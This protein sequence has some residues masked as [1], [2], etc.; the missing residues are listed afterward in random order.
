MCRP[1][2]FA[3]VYILHILIFHGPHAIV[4]N[5]YSPEKGE[6]F[7]ALKRVTIQDIADACG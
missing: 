6:P 2:G 4:N 5:A 7:M 3:S 1:A